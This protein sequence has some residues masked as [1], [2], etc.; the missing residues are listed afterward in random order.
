[1]DCEIYRNTNQIIIRKLSSELGIPSGNTFN[2]LKIINIY[3]PYL[4]GYTT[5]FFL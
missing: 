2:R 4:D 5:E 3:N 1:M